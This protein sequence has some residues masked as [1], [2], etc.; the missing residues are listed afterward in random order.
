[1]NFCLQQFSKC[2]A[3]I[4]NSSDAYTLFPLAQIQTLS[5]TI[6][7]NGCFPMATDRRFNANVI[8]GKT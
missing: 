1:M 7:I 8:G 5:F 6:W 2:G 3:L 4:H